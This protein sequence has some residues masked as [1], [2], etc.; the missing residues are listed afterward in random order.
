VSLRLKQP[1]ELMSSVYSSPFV[2]LQSE[3]VL[4]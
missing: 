2:L 4:A 3:Q 1:R